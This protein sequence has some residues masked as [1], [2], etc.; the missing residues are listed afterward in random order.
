MEG[1]PHYDWLKTSYST[2]KVTFCKYASGHPCTNLMFLV[3]V[4]VIAKQNQLN[5]FHRFFFGC[6]KNVARRESNALCF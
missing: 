6:C 3:A 5:L 4:P 1:Y 2:N